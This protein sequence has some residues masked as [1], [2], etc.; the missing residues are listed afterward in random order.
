METNKQ[1]TISGNKAKELYANSNDN[2]FKQLLEENF[3]KEFFIPKKLTDYI[4]TFKDVCNHM[5]IN[6]NAWLERYSDLDKDTIA[7]EKLKLIVKCFNEGWVPD[8]EN[9][10]QYKY[11]PYFCMGGASGVGFSFCGY[12]NRITASD[13][14]VHL[15]LKTTELSTFVG[16]TFENEYKEWMIIE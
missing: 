2:S 7:Y 16:K 13:V 6:Y 4:K 8:W 9:S 5:E 10:S 3:G 1:L 11:F 14:G 15:C 12:D